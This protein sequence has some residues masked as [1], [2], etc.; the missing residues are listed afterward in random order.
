MKTM[1]RIPLYMAIL[2]AS[3]A[4]V[5]QTDAPKAAPKPAAPP[6]VSV[7]INRQ[8]GNVEG[9]FVPL[10]DA[11]PE[12]KYDFAPTNGEFKGVRTFGQMVKHVAVTNQLLAAALLGQK[13]PVT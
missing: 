1:I 10:A 9:Q 13:P 8:I 6:T 7:V 12:D 5:A 4:A 2:L 3:V 11:M